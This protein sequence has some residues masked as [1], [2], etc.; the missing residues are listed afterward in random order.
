MR[1]CECASVRQGEEPVNVRADSLADNQGPR[2]SLQ[3]TRRDHM[4]DASLDHLTQGQRLVLSRHDENHLPRVHDGLDADGERH[5]GHGGEVVVE[6]TAVVED[7]LV[8]EGL[9]AGA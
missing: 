6:E 5:A 2:M 9:D 1:V 7:G 3:S 4:V 8:G